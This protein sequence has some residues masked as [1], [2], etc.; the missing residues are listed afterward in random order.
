MLDPVKLCV[1]KFKHKRTYLVS[2]HCTR[3]QLIALLREEDIDFIPKSREQR[4]IESRIMNV[5]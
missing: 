1:Q 3:K 2:F 5:E 4:V